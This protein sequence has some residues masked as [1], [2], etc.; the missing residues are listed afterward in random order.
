MQELIEGAVR[1]PQSQGDT[2]G[3]TFGQPFAE[4]TPEGV[5]NLVLY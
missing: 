2:E 5:T 4:T 3:K 1:L